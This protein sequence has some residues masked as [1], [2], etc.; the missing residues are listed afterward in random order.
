MSNIVTYLN[1]GRKLK[2]TMEANW[3]VQ[4]WCALI[5]KITPFEMTLCLVTLQTLFMLK[6]NQA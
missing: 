5:K 4:K 2:T 1:P 6:R 3:R